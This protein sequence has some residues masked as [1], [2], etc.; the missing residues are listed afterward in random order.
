MCHKDVPINVLLDLCYIENTSALRGL[1]DLSHKFRVRNRLAALHDADDGGLGL[2]V[3]ISCDSFVGLLVFFFCL[4]ELH[5][6]DLDAVLFVRESRV[7]RKSVIRIDIA[8]F[9][10]FCQGT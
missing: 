4:L 9:G 8:A 10:M 1:D 6:V 7:D 5:L 2:K 3:A